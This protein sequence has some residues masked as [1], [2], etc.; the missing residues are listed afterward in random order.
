MEMTKNISEYYYDQD[1]SQKLSRHTTKS[2]K[3]LQMMAINCGISEKY[4]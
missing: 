1:P 3:D 2:I 4:S